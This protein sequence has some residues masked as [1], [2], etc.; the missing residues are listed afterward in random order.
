MGTNDE[1][2]VNLEPNSEDIESND[3]KIVTETESTQRLLLLNNFIKIKLIVNKYKF[4]DDRHQC[5]V[6][7]A[8]EEDDEES[9]E[10]VRPCRCRGTGISLINLV[11]K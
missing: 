11:I 7:I 9:T 10:W 3:N 2:G 4:S 8:T 6:C 5:W 1:I